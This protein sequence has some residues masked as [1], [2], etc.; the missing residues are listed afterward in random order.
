ML[1]GAAALTAIGF[2]SVVFYLIAYMVTNLTAFGIISIVSEVVGSDE[3]SD[4]KGVAKKSPAIGLALMAAFLSLA[5][6][7]PFAGFVGKILL[8]SAGVGSAQIPWLLP[9]VAIGIL[10][11]IIGLILL[12][13]GHQNS[14]HI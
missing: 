7:P 13:V 9:L 8:F 11:S 5:G 12:F 3:I 6:I 10:N 14:I 1:I 4:Y 2:T